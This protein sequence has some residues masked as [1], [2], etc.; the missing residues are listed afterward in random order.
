MVLCGV[1]TGEQTTASLDLE[2]KSLHKGLPFLLPIFTSSSRMKIFYAF[3]KYFLKKI[4]FQVLTF[5]KN[6]V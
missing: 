1:R 3:E 2:R 5:E 4:F 6:R